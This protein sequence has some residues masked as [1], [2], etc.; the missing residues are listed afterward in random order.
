V[1][2]G[3]GSITLNAAI[4]DANG[5]GP[6]TA[7]IK[8]G[9]NQTSTLLN[10][11]GPSL[12]ASHAYTAAGSYSISVKVSRGSSFGSS[13][14]S[15]VVVFDPNGGS[16]NADGWFNAPLGSLPGNPAFIGKI[17]FESNVK[18][19]Q[20]STVP[21]GT[22][23]VNLPGKDFVANSLTYLTISGSGLQ[24]GG[25]GTINN[26][27]SYGFLLTGI[28]GKLDGKTMPDKVRIRI[29]NQATG[30]VICDSQ[31]NAPNSA[32]PAIVLGGGTINIKK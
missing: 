29:W 4:V 5:T 13:T 21:T 32:S 6:Y 10:V 28:D 15:P 25:A 26:A 18:Y 30:A 23:K 14:F 12:S 9:D 3:S 16:M 22:A 27:G 8:W 20:G 1:A 2:L 11:N 7:E 24:V 19:E 31:M 17:H